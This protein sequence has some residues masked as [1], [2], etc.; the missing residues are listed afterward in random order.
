MV[1]QMQMHG[2]AW[3]VD[4]ERHPQHELCK[5][6]ASCAI[7]FAPLCFYTTPLVVAPVARPPPLDRTQPHL[8]LRCPCV[9]HTSAAGQRRKPMKVLAC[10]R[11]LSSAVAPVKLGFG[12][13]GYTQ[14][15]AGGQ[16]RSA[17]DGG[18]VGCTGRGGPHACIMARLAADVGLQRRAHRSHSVEVSSAV[19][20]A[21]LYLHHTVAGPCR[22]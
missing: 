2:C 4:G 15:G 9:S 13:G 22:A 12:C 21:G 20:A 3:L 11:G 18:G 14:L 1:L 10:R 19:A 8:S 6:H 7:D 5:A 17:Q 16:V